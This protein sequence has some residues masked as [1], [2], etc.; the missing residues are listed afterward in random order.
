MLGTAHGP[1]GAHEPKLARVPGSWEEGMGGLAG[2]G[3]MPPPGGMGLACRTPLSPPVCRSLH[4]Y[5]LLLANVCGGR[6]STFCMCAM[7]RKCVPLL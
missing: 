5:F 2:M 7:F 3:L 6:C 4:A 1:G